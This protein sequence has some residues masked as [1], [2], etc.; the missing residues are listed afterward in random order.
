MKHWSGPVNRE[1]SPVLAPR[2]LRPGVHSAVV[3]IVAVVI[4]S[5]PTLAGAQLDGPAPAVARGLLFDGARMVTF[6][7]LGPGR[8][9]WDGFEAFV[10]EHALLWLHEPAPLRDVLSRCT[11]LGVEHVS[12]VSERLGLHRVRSLD[13]RW[14]A[15]SAA[16]GHLRSA[17]SAADGHLRSA[18]S[19][20]DGHL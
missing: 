9:R 19:A 1:A 14:S 8:V 18:G 6:E 13:R 15:G 16:D 17:G 20:A 4:A 12:V 5:S 11:A 7:R 10:D 2:G 3:A